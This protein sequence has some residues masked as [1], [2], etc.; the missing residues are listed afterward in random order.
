MQ[1]LI[2]SHTE[3]YQSNDQIYGWGPTVREID[4]LASLFTRVTHLAF[5]YPGEPPSSALP[6]PAKNVTF[7]PVPASGGG[8]LLSKFG[9]LMRIPLYLWKIS[10][11]LGKADVVHV[12]CPAVISLLALLLLAIRRT[13]RTRWIKYA[14]NWRPHAQSEEALSYQWQRWWLEKGLAR[15]LVTVNGNW[16]GQPAYV[17]SFLNPCLT[18]GEQS[19]GAIAASSK[20]LQDHPHLVFVG[21]LEQAKGV[22]IALRVVARLQSMGVFAH[23]DLAGDGLEQKKFEQL[24]GHLNIQDQIR[25]HGW[26]SRP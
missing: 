23:L 12:R 24:A 26:V 21:R 10:Q 8:G 14:G 22:E 19:E 17:R 16:P 9:I 3:H 6:Y 25:F 20:N 2:I 11:E 13:P 5:F 18:A 15:A 7:V 1:L 4:Q